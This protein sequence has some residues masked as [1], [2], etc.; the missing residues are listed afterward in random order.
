MPLHA[1]HWCVGE[2]A[3]DVMP[4]R[5]DILGLSNR[6]YPQAIATAQTMVLP[7]KRPIR[8]VA[9]P[10]FVATKLEAFHGRGDGHYLFSHDLEDLVSIFDGREQLMEECRACWSRAS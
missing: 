4:T 1:I 5:S 7:S 2:L 6:W 10:L 8:V 3:V 9:A